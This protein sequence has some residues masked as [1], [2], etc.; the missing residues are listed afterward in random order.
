MNTSPSVS[1]V[2]SF[3]TT[4]RDDGVRFGDCQQQRP[5]LIFP[6]MAREYTNLPSNR[7]LGVAAMHIQHILKSLEGR[8]IDA[9]PVTRLYRLRAKATA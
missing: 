2:W 7:D 4:L 3:W 8:E 6:K 5:S 9:Y 1:K